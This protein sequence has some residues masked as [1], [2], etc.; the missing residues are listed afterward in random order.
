MSEESKNCQVLK[1]KV[2]GEESYGERFSDNGQVYDWNKEKKESLE[3]WKIYLAIKLLTPPP[4]PQTSYWAA[5][6]TAHL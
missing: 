6:G 2:S 3:I 4:R 1:G 5:C